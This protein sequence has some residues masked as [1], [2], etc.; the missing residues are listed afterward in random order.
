MKFWKDVGSVIVVCEY[1]GS[2][3]DVD[4]VLKSMWKCYSGL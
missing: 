1:N 2:I 4:R 3:V